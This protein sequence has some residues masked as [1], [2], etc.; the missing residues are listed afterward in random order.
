MKKNAKYLIIA[1]AA[2]VVLGGAAAALALTG[3]G[4]AAE[5]TSSAASSSTTVSLITDRTEE[6]L[7]SVTVTNENGEIVVHAHVEEVVTSEASSEEDASS[8]ASEPET[9]VVYEVE[10]LEDLA[11]NSSSVS[12]VAKAGYIL[13]ATKTIGQVDN[14]SD[15]G[16]ADPALTVEA[17][18]QDGSVFSYDVGIQNGSYYYVKT[19]ESDDVY[20]ASISSTLFGT[21]NDLADTALYELEI[22]EDTSSAASIAQTTGTYTDAAIFDRIHLYGSA[23]ER[24]VVIEYDAQ[25][26]Y[27]MKEPRSAATDSTRMSNITA[28]LTSLSADSL[29]KAHPTEEDLETY[30]LAEPAAVCEF[31]S[32]GNEYVL[33]VSAADADGSRYI[34]Y[35]G[36][37]AVFQIANDSVTAWADVSPFYLQSVLTLLPNIVDVHTM[38]LNY[39][40]EEYVFTIDRAVDEE[41]STEDNTAYTYTV[42]NADGLE[43]DYEENFKHF[44]LAFISITVSEDTWEMP[45]GEP[46]LSCTYTYHEGDETD[47]IEYYKVSDRRYAIVQN[48]QLMGLALSDLVNTATSDL[49]L[50][51]N[52]EEVPDPN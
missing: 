31:T 12:T 36:I 5:E 4:D 18:Y 22:G 48:G 25:Q 42:K 14:L 11:L 20:M 39:G 34:V 33:T 26:G 6:D 44:Y 29:A 45:E 52:G 1:G 8:E 19:S 46:D 28:A 41:N 38:T 40:G 37:D 43:L 49:V 30:G 9:E 35:S 24:E 21:V 16:L 3:G 32:G 27:L 50:L 15:F 23:F 17:V 7:A 51:N 10:G 13:T 2:V 47:T